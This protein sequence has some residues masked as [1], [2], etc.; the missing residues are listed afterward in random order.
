LKNPEKYAKV[1]KN[2]REAAGMEEKTVGTVISV[3]KQWWFKVNTKPVRMNGMDGA[4]FPHII[5]VRYTVDGVDYVKRKWYWAG[6]PVPREGASVTV[7]YCKEK[8]AKA[9][10]L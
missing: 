10:I 8:P 9:K 1:K 2:E 3:S 7:A 6:W 5:K 4:E